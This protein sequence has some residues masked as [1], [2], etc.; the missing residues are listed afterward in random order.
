MHVLAA[1]VL[2]GNAAVAL[3][4]HPLRKLG[5]GLPRTNGL[6][7]AFLM[8][9]MFSSYQTRNAD[10]FLA[11]ERTSTGDEGDR[12]RWIRLRI[13][14]HFPAR[15]GVVFTQLFAVRHWDVHGRVAQRRAWV[16]LAARI[17][18]RHNRLHPEAPIAR[19]RFGQIDWPQD[20]R[21]YR[22]GK[23]APNVRATTWYEDRVARGAAP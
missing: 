12:G 4:P 11:G 18:A 7:D 17:R 1:V 9:G 5:L 3:Q 19:V 2:Y 16:G 6:T 23:R 8:T 13:R 20:P 10:M 14:E 22:A 21:G 15:Q